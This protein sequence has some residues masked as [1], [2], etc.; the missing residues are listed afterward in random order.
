MNLSRLKIIRVIIS[1]IFFISI[2]A[3]F[4][5]IRNFLS[6]AYTNYF[7]YLQF[8][9]SLIKFLKLTGIAAAGFIF[10]IIL[11]L[12]FGRFYCSSICPL[13][14]F[15]DIFSYMST[16]FKKKKH[17]KLRKPSNLIRYLFLVIPVIFIVSGNLFAVNLLD[18]YSNFGR[19]FTQLFKPILIELNNI[20]SFVLDKFKIYSIF[21]IELKNPDFVLILF[22]VSFLILVLGFSLTAGRLFCNT[23]CPVGTILGL[24]S[25]LSI[26]KI[27]IDEENCI[28][29]NLCEKVC[30]S[31]CIDKKAKAV[32]FSRCVNCYNCFTVCPTNGINYSYGFK[33]HSNTIHEKVDYKKREFVVSIIAFLIGT[34]KLAYTQTKIVAKKLSTIPI[35]K[36]N[37]VSPPGSISLQHFTESCTACHL[38]ISACPTQVLQPAF[39]EYGIWGILQPRMDYSFN[40]CNFECVVCSQVCPTGAIIPI[41]LDKKKLTQLGKVKFIK[42]N[43]I[44][45]SEKTDC[46]ACAEHC[47]SKA[48]IMIPY[49]KIRAPE[50]KDEYCIGCGACEYACP[51]K[52]YKAIYVEGNSV[53]QQAKVKKE[54]KIEE[55]INYKEDFPF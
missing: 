28:S 13:G 35:I 15:Q 1:L 43:C 12:L 2:S 55:K 6:P 49:E 45:Y 52:P 40:F 50:I 7:T 34:S 37:P 29:C 19:I 8:I 14:T 53:H 46:G 16:R 30:K 11:T 27:K 23:I 5:D 36:K 26:F 21:A 17:F 54:N 47:P 9:P 20:V 51:V 41:H 31:G 3:L 22:P 39:L 38:C 48:V 44:V 25:K 33:K 32:D 4:L 24:I 42:D 10:I 18:P